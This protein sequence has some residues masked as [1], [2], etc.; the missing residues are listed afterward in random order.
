[1][2]AEDSP[3]DA[4]WWA[5]YVSTRMKMMTEPLPYLHL[6]HST[7]YFD[8]TQIR[9]VIDSSGPHAA[10]LLAIDS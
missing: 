6:Q 10:L 8:P 7:M 4:I 3:V 2:A 9:Y 5:S 1:M